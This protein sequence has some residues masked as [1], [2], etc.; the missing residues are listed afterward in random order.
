MG[1]NDGHPPTVAFPVLAYLCGPEANETE[2][3]AA[4]FTKNGE[5]RILNLLLNFRYRCIDP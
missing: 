3:G 2:I 1:V 4:L 5:R